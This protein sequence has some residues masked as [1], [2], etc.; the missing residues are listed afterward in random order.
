MGKNGGVNLSLLLREAA[1]RAPQKPALIS[2]DGSVLTYEHLDRLADGVAAGL[3]SAGI[4]RGD[5]VLV[6]LP[7]SPEFVALYYGCLRAGAIVVPLNPGLSDPEIQKI[8]SDSGAKGSIAEGRSVAGIT[9]IPHADWFDGSGNPIEDAVVTGDDVAML[10]YTSGTTGEPK[11]VILSHGNLRSNLDQQM[12]VDDGEVTEDDVILLALPFFHIFGLNVALGLSVANAATGVLT[13]SFD[14]VD[15]LRSIQDNKITVIFGA[16]PLYIGL[17]STP[18]ADQYDL[19]SVR[20]AVSGAAARAPEILNGV[21]ELFTVDIYE[22]Y[23]LTETSPALSSNRVGETP[24]PGSIGRAIP[25]VELR[26]VDE[27]GEEVELGDPGEIEVR[28]PNVFKGYWN[29]EDETAA[30]FRDGWFR[31][32]DVAV[33]DEEGYLYLVDRKRDLIIV[34]G[35][36]VFPSEVEHA[37]EEN[38]KVFEAAVIGVPHPYTG[39]SVSAYV[40]LAE[41]ET[42]DEAE[43]LAD[44]ETRLARFKCPKTIEIVDSLPHLLTGKVLRRALRT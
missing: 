4:A 31:T 29:R 15:V 24:R 21:R 6:L 39:E 13:G 7:N 41:G 38:P 34:S 14:P 1:G 22:G 43:L 44:V 9:D 23:G 19:S 11:G 36:N 8:A 26:L 35:F 18:G 40:I 25:G 16:P 42:A 2:P 33:I 30:V 10:V 28:G 27:N 5:R 37:L 3:G 17:I 32:G 20:L 12:A